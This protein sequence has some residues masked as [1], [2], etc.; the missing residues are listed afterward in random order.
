MVGQEVARRPRQRP[1]SEGLFPAA[2]P[3]YR[4]DEDR[5]RAEE[6]GFDSRLVEPADAVSLR[7]TMAGG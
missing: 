1:G 6:A 2:L 5:G 4:Q 7:L 3:G